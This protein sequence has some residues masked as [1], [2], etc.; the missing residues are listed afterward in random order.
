MMWAHPHVEFPFKPGIRTL[1][2]NY[3]DLEDLEV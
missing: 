1:V 3:L 2:E